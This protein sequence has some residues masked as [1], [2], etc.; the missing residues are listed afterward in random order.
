MKSTFPRL[1]LSSSFLPLFLPNFM[2]ALCKTHWVHQVCINIGPSTGAWVAS[3]GRIS[4][5]N[6]QFLFQQPSLSNR[7]LGSCRISLHP[8]LPCW[9]LDWLDLVH[10]LSVQLLWVRMCNCTIMSSIYY[11]VS[12]V[13]AYLWFLRSSHF[14]FW[15]WSQLFMILSKLQFLSTCSL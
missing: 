1:N 6:W 10:V 15:F 5:G 8:P 9:H 14:L 2:C 11:L 3:R 13:D 12:T 7:S 4:E